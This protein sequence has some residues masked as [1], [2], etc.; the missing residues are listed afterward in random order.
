MVRS[1]QH[2]I[3]SIRALVNRISSKITM[4]VDLLFHPKNKKAM[5]PCHVTGMF[6]TSLL[7]TVADDYKSR[8]R[9]RKTYLSN[10]W[11]LYFVT[12]VIC[13]L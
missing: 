10:H 7:S 6:Q 11:Y 13:L 4:A 2:L 12:T 5:E 9:A 1:K 3:D 8:E